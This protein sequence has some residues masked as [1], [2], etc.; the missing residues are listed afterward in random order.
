[1]YWKQLLQVFMTCICRHKTCFRAFLW[2]LWNH[3]AITLIFYIVDEEKYNSCILILFIFTFL[4][5]M[6]KHSH[7]SVSRVSSSW[8]KLPIVFLPSSLNAQNYHHS[9]QTGLW[10][11]ILD[12]VL[13]WEKYRNY[14]VLGSLLQKKDQLTVAQGAK[15]S[16]HI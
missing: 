7:S 8:A 11:L 9:L 2:S 4:G 3:H 15:T 1:M 12:Q 14:T 5:S 6:N 10:I 13:I 16:F